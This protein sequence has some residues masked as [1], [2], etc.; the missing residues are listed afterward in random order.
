MAHP[1][2][3]TPSGTHSI[4]TPGGGPEHFVPEGWEDFN[5]G[6]CPCGEVVVWNEATDT[7]EADRQ[8]RVFVLSATES[9]AV[10][11]MLE[12]S[13]DGNVPFAYDMIERQL[14]LQDEIEEFEASN[15]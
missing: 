1:A 14:R 13:S 6:I 15:D 10:R 9:I 11:D 12:L 4:H 5:R 3:H 8:M 2:L 7:W